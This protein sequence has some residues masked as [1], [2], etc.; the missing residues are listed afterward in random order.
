M[1]SSRVIQAA[2]VFQELAVAA[3]KIP[4]LLARPA[5]AD[6]H[7]DKAEEEEALEVAAEEVEEDK[8]LPEEAAMTPM[9]TAVASTTTRHDRNRNP[10]KSHL[11]HLLEV[12]VAGTTTVVVVA[13]MMEGT[14]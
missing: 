1:G 9:A 7:R 10:S 4:G 2:V 12:A 13:E 14:T 5:M 11:V 3:V 6:R 8:D